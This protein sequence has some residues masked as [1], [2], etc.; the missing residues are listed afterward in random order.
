MVLEVF[1]VQHVDNG[2]HHVGLVRGNPVQQGLE[3]A[4]V[5][6]WV[7]LEWVGWDWNGLVGLRMEWIEDGV[8]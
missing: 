5:G 1:V 8:G 2:S 4:C 7:G 6:G 3:P